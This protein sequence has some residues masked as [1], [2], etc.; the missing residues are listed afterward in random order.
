MLCSINQWGD[1][2]ENE[3]IIQLQEVYD[4]LWIDAKTLIKD[5]KASISTVFLF[6]V[7]MF[8]FSIIQVANVTEMYSKITVNSTTL[9]YFYLVATSFGVIVSPLAGIFFLRFYFQINKRYAKLIQLE[10]IIED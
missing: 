1:K 7:V 4:E 6:S 2:M 3:K 10:K 8:S 9:D 5:M